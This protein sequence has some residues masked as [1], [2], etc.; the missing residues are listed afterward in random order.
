VVTFSQPIVNGSDRSLKTNIEPITGA[1]AIVSQLQGVFYK[2]RDAARRQVGLI[3]QDVLMPLP[4][5]VFDVGPELGED[6]KPRG[7]EGAPNLLGIAYP[8]IVA[9]LIEAI[10]ELNAKLA[11]AGAV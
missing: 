1:L 10:K 4:E 5:V 9:V 7:G 2:H 3:A 11:G 6:G 8:N